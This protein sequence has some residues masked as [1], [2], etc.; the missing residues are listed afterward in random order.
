M[1]KREKQH[2]ILRNK[3]EQEN[4]QLLKQLN[5]D[6]RQQ[7]ISSD[8]S[9]DNSEEDNKNDSLENEKNELTPIYAGILTKMEE[10]EEIY[11]QGFSLSAL[12]SMLNLPARVISKA[13]NVCHGSN[14]HQLLNEYRIREAIKR[15]HDP[16]SAN[17][18]IESIA[19]SVGFK[20]RTSFATLFKK[21]TGLTPSE[22]LR[23]AQNDELTKI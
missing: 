21:S 12:A 13:I 18:T 11:N 7:N 14:F 19:E 1:L 15:L 22:Y 16:S 23:M 3:W 6:D 8:L 20:S 5:S 2:A 10:S 4:S 9:N 17:L